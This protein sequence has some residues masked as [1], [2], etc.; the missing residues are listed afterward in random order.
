[1]QI[2]EN[3]QKLIYTIITLL[4]NVSKDYAIQNIEHFIF[5]ISEYFNVKLDTITYVVDDKSIPLRC[6]IQYTCVLA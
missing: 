3:Q 4:P 1:M 5:I 2:F 6:R